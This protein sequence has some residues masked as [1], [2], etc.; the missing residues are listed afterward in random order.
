MLRRLELQ[1]MDAAARVVRT[2]FDQALPALAGLIYRRGIG[3][4]P[5]RHSS[6]LVP[7]DDA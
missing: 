1:D 4:H 2:A 3:E 6:A 5:V 7:R